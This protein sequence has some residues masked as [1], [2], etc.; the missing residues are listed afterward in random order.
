MKLAYS[1]ISLLAI[2]SILYSSTACAQP[3]TNMYEKDWKAIEALEADGKTKSALEAT[4]KLYTKIQQNTDDPQQEAQLIKAL[5]IMNKQQV[6][7]EEDGLVKAIARLEQEA[8]KATFPMNAVLQSMLAELYYNY[9]KRNV[10]KFRNRTATEDFDPVDMQTWDLRR[11]THKIY[12]LYQASLVNQKSQSINLEQFD[13]ILTKGEYIKGLRPT[14]YDFLLHRALDFYQ[15]DHY[16][17]T[18]PAYKFYLDDPKDFAAVDEFINRSLT[19]KDS[20]SPKFQAML[21]YQEGL[22][23]HQK[24]KNPAAFVDLNLNRLSFVKSNSVLNDKELL[25]EKRLKTLYE[26]YKTIEPGANIAYELA[27]LYQSQG[28]SYKAGTEDPKRWKLK[29]AR[30]LCSTIIEQ[31]PKSYGA[32]LCKNL[33]VAI[34]Q[35][36]LQV[37]VEKINSIQQEA[38]ANVSYKNINQLYFKAV[39]ISHQIAQKIDDLYG[40]EKLNYINGISGAYTWEHKLPNEG[41]FQL[42]STEIAI[43]ALPNG[44]YVIVAATDKKFRYEKNAFAHANIYVSNLRLVQ[45]SNNSTYEYAVVNA[46][47]G[48]AVVN[49][50]VDFFVWQSNFLGQ[51]YEQKVYTTKTDKNGFFKDGNLNTNKNYYSIKITHQKDVLHLDDNYYRYNYRERERVNQTTHF[52]L[53]RAIYRPGQTIYFK[54]LVLEHTPGKKIPDLVTNSSR[55]VVLYDANY[56][57][58][59]ELEL[60]T[61]EYGTFHGSFNAPNSG[62]TGS[63]H[64][65]DNVTNSKKYFRVEEYKRPKFEVTALPVK[66]AYKLD[67]SI[68]VKGQAKAYAG[69]NID[70]AKVTYRVVRKV[71]FPYWK[72]HWGWYIPYNQEEQQ[73][74]FGETTTNEKGEYSIT[75]K[76]QPDRSIPADKKPSFTYYVYADVI[77]ITGETHSATSSVRV[78]YVALDLNINLPEIL[79]KS[80]A[81]SLYINSRNLNGQ[82]EAA[83]GKLVIE[84]LQMPNQVYKN[85]YWSK[86]D[87][88]TLKEEDFKKKFPYF[89]YKNEDIKE[90]WAVIKEM[91]N[92]KFDTKQN[93]RVAYSNIQNWP[94]G[95]YK[96]TVQSQDKY[97]EKIELKENYRELFKMIF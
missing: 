45:R 4:Q 10:S 89:A 57:K 60:T 86:P 11:I 79:E 77:D 47:T 43:P 48:A 56:Q 87:F 44:R 7:L 19:A 33:Q 24:D 50:T 34:D 63:M 25:L 8:Q 97:G 32:S 67:D 95:M 26:Q 53:D 27:K 17:L 15:T 23:F 1:W 29:E 13:P 40:K 80:A 83:Q 54:G 2:L 36:S 51:N 81:D 94:Q 96:V 82:F 12:E 93:P 28:N 64:L 59:T 3:K 65:D 52:F 46:Q 37:N 18:Q 58:V 22:Q 6:Q 61:N 41:D 20:M 14:L 49:A 91:V 71:Q 92:T 16:Y 74:T 72:W 30:E 85:R 42:H 5:L 75:F 66:E 88:Y 38:L 78:G 70:G 76:A 68:T 9:L 90:T 73:M 21:L 31:Y 62:L 39:P 55:T 35:K 84:Q 69:N